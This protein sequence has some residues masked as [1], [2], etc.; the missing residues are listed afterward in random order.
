MEIRAHGSLVFD[1]LCRRYAQAPIFDTTKGLK[2]TPASKGFAEGAVKV[3]QSHTDFSKF[4]PGDILVAPETTPAYVPLMRMASAILTERGGVT[5]HAAIVSRE[6]KKPCIIS[7]PGL[8]SGL[9]DGDIVEADAEK[10]VV[11]ILKNTG[12]QGSEPRWDLW[13][14][15][16]FDLFSTSVWNEWY[17]SPHLTELFG[18]SF[19]RGL[20][21]EYPKGT[22]KQYRE[23]E[24]PASFGEKIS[25]TATK[26]ASKAGELLSMAERLNAEA[27]QMIENEKSLSFDEALDFLVRLAHYSIFIP[28]F[29]GEALKAAYPDSELSLRC[30]KLRAV[31]L[32][33]RFIEKVL[34]PSAERILAEA[35]ISREYLPFV[36]TNGLRQGRFEVIQDR[37]RLSESGSSFLVR[38]EGS[39]EQVEYVADASDQMRR[40]GLVNDSTE[41]RGSV[42][43]KGVQK[44]RAR[45]LL[46]NAT[47]AHFADGDILVA[48]S[49][50]PE[51]LPL[52]R[53]AGAIVTDEG[54]A[55][56]HAAI[57][58]RE[59]KKPCIIGTKIATQALRDGDLVEVV[60]II[61]RIHSVA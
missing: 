53:R 60:R 23:S 22:A 5:S 1:E 40:L 41:I 50:N 6:L 59:L 58:A 24:A 35:G 51:I 32:Y 54:G 34:R 8:I 26:S 30:E 3:V 47:L 4:K 10:G 39:E 9:K 44:G 37:R 42:A 36:T 12:R 2:G 29:G 56:S 45:I 15:R 13:L 48:I 33:P 28:Y 49:T 55:T 31:S 52:M 11:R 17:V 14:S 21:V 27:E 61:E 57:L 46:G 7:I 25:S 43:Y 18:A 20:F 16:P 38:Y 19:E